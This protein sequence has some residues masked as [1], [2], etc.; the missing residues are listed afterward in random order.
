M[1]THGQIRGG[2]RA[3]AAQGTADQVG[4]PSVSDNRSARIAAVAHEGHRL[5]FD[6]RAGSDGI[7][8]GRGRVV[9][10]DVLNRQGLCDLS[11]PHPFI[12]L[13]LEGNAMDTHGQIRGGKRALAAQGG[14][15][16]PGLTGSGLKLLENEG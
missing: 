1:D 12:V 16:E 10:G 15:Q 8:D 5:A 6:G 4:R 7:D 11:R 3:L 9:G 2:K 14:K 13:D